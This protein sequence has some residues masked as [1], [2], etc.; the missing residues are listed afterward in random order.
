MKHMLRLNGGKEPHF[1]FIQWS[2]N[3]INPNP[4]TRLAQAFQFDNTVR[5]FK[6]TVI[7]IYV[8]IYCH[9]LCL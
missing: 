5:P 6:S 4:H 9:C 1:K 3:M 7:T 2:P 8:S